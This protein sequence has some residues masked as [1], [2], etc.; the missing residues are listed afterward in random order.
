MPVIT[1]KRVKTYTH[2]K[3]SKKNGGAK[4]LYGNDNANDNDND[5]GNDNDNDNEAGNDNGMI[6]NNI[7]RNTINRNTINRNSNI[8]NNSIN[9]NNTNSM[10]ETKNVS[11]IEE[12]IEEGNMNELQT[13]EENIS[14]D[15]MYYFERNENKITMQPYGDEVSVTLNRN[16]IIYG[17]NMNVITFESGIKETKTFTPKSKV[18][19][20]ELF[21]KKY[22]NF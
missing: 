16:E 3:R 10:I 11:V 19:G 13:E 15:K 22:I 20:E 12:N 7:N 2:A 4:E 8:E 6:E 14:S 21:I 18:L 1:K 17:L 9:R 5:N